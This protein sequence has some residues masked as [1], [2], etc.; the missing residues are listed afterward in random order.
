VASR[1]SISFVRVSVLA[2]AALCTLLAACGDM[3]KVDDP[4]LKQIEEMLNAQL[5]P[6]T[7]SSLVFQ[8][9]A[10][11][12]YPIEPAGRSDALMVIIRHI[13]QQKL[14]PVTA[15]V[16]FYFDKN[17]KLIKTDIVRTM[18]EPLPKSEPQ[19]SPEPGTEA[20]PGSKP[21]Q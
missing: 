8:F 2:L 15:R 6:G 20:E 13:D 11:R 1:P 17:D 3:M 21:P 4:Q 14:K 16:T 19:T 10:A 18:N 5:P 9:V 12:G 7:P